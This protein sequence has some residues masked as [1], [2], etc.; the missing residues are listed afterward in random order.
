MAAMEWRAF[1]L[2]HTDDNY[3]REGAA[4]VLSG[5]SASGLCVVKTLSIS[6]A[7]SPSEYLNT[8]SNILDTNVNGVLYFGGLTGLGKL[9][10][11]MEEFSEAGRLQWVIS[12]GRFAETLTFAY[13]KGVITVSPSA[14]TVSEFQDFWT[15]IDPQDPPFT[16]PNFQEFHMAS[17]R[18]KFSGITNPAYVN[19]SDCEATT[20]EQRRQ[21]FSQEGNTES[22]ILAVYAY[23]RALKNAHLEKCGGNPGLCD[24]LLRTTSEEFFRDYLR[25]VDLTF[26]DEERLPSLASASDAAAPKRLRFDRNG[27]VSEVA[28]DVWN[29]NDRSGETTFMKVVKPDFSVYNL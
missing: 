26:G 22:G 13:A 2:V 7:T 25:D 6:G 11:A 19:F 4:A 15:S 20:Q 24:T 8:V 14:R 12:D 3:G 27:D 29:V 5:A 21:A 16:S 9:M 28:F 1:V 10:E 17:N 23:A 18:C